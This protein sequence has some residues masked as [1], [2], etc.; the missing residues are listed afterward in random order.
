MVRDKWISL[1]GGKVKPESGYI[2][3]FDDVVQGVYGPILLQPLHSALLILV[4]SSLQPSHEHSELPELVQKWLVCKKSNVL[5]IVICLV[6]CAA[7]VDFL[8]T[9]WLVRVYALQ[10]A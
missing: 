9:L 8:Y 6:S 10:Y 7:L 3:L 4:E 5:G 2:P 1:G